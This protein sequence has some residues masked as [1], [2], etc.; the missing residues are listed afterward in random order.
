MKQ[1]VVIIGIGEL[2]AVFARGL[3]RL[4]HPVFPITRDM[5]MALES[6]SIPEPA[7]V[8]LAVA[9][10]DLQP[11]LSA[12]PTPWR[13]RLALLQNELLPRDWEAQGLR[14]PTVISV[15]FEKKQGMDTKVLLP[16]PVWG[17]GAALLQTALEGID[18][19]ARVLD[20]AD[21]LLH[22]L[23]RKNLYILTSNIAGL[24]TGGTVGELWGHHQQLARE[25]ATEVLQIQAWLSGQPLDDAALIAGMVEA[26]EADPDHGC[27]GRSAPA[28]LQR[29]LTHA[30][31]AGLAVPRLRAI[32][33]DKLQSG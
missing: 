3:L 17:P 11:T 26:F 23:V 24:V 9:E 29:A 20:S 5:D 22:E 19:P 16:S 10:D 27:T 28:R 13:A 7:L 21:E 2:G 33:A 30:E 8:L 12:I 18:I 6:A 25:V 14:A 1:P 15:W 32:A 31:A 4:G